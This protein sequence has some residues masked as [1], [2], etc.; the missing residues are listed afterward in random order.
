MFFLVFLLWLVS[1]HATAWHVIFVHSY[2][3]QTYIA[4]WH[5]IHRDRSPSGPEKRGHGPAIHPF[6]PLKHS[7]LLRCW[8]P[9]STFLW[10]VCFFSCSTYWPWTHSKLPYLKSKILPSDIFSLS[11]MVSTSIIFT[12]STFHSGL[13]PKQSVF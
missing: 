3:V 7:L 4:Y 1:N 2:H 12:S 5:C 11:K 13:I 9:V 6:C 8:A 10:L